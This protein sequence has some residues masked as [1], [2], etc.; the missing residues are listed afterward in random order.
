MSYPA[1]EAFFLDHGR[2]YARWCVYMALQP[3]FLSHA[4]PKDAKVEVVR[5]AARVSTGATSEA[6]RWMELRGYVVVHGRDQRGTPA[7][8]LAYALP[9]IA[10]Q[11]LSVNGLL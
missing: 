9:S 2:T 7:L 4:V 5:T 8:T 6:L 3:P 11:L 1:Y 10:P